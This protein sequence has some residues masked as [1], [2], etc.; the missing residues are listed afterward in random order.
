MMVEAGAEPVTLETT[1]APAWHDVEVNNKRDFGMWDDAV[2][3]GERDLIVLRRGD[4]LYSLS[5]LEDPLPK[6]LVKDAD[7]AFTRII[8]CVAAEDRLWVFLNSTETDVFAV[9]AHSGDR[10]HFRIPGL[11]L[12][13]SHAPRIQSHVMVPHAGAVILMVEGGDR[14]SWPRDGNRPVYFWMSLQSGSVVRFPIG[15]DLDCFSRDQRIAVFKMPAE[16]EF[17]RR[18]LQ[19]IAM[20]SGEI[21][22]AI[23]NRHLDG[24]VP[25]SWTETQ[26]VKPIYTHRPQMGGRAF[27]D[28]L[29]VN[30]QALTIRLDLEQP[31]YLAQ[32]MESNGFV[33]FRL[34]REG[35]GSIPS[36]LWLVNVGD[37]AR[38]ERVA[39]QVSDFSLLE[40]GDCVITTFGDGAR[41]QS[42][43]TYLRSFHDG[44]VWN[45]LEGVARL[46]E[47]D[48]E[49]AGKDSVL[50]GM[51]VR[52][53]PGFGTRRP[54]VLCLFEHLRMDVRSFGGR[55][56]EEK[57]LKPEHWR[58]AVILTSTRERLMTNLF[59]EGPVPE[60]LWLH[61]SGR[62]ISGSTA[63]GK[64]HLSS[65]DFETPPG[66]Q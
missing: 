65:C 6:E 15:W 64:V 43:E 33:G 14:E 21:S 52:L 53:I 55:S 63:G 61:H 45:V 31:F 28:G 59:R 30:G 9:D 24:Y 62:L 8:A 35:T 17:Q 7:L 11:T 1:K 47:L 25:F 32:A 2:V 10:S 57:T 36:P 41:Q 39:A 29:S 42:S 3:C 46:P 51:S 40:G 49:F 58:R 27:F 50:D 19:A 37:P 60:I 12:P 20:H 5:M 22:D 38:P 44:S 26:A 56:P 34:R 18:P 13:G 54:M 4:T 66:H 48:R 16:E 23:P